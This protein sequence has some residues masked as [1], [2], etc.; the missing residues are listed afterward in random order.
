MTECFSLDFLSVDKNEQ[1]SHR[2][3]LTTEDTG[4]AWKGHLSFTMALLQGCW[5][6]LGDIN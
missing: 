6:A 2:E 1:C 3:H 4:L 5:N